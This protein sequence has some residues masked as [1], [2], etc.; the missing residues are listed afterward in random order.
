MI[1]WIKDFLFQCTARFKLDGTLSILV[2]NREDVP[3]GG[4]VSPSILFLVYINDI[5]IFNG[6]SLGLDCTINRLTPNQ[7]QVSVEK[8]PRFCVVEYYTNQKLK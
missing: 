5:T 8:M 1:K 4:I 2:K 6:L 3:Q 7:T